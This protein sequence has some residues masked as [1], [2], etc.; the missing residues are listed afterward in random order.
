M[1][2]R[3]RWSLATQNDMALELIAMDDQLKIREQRTATQ[4]PEQASALKVCMRFLCALLAAVSVCGAQHDASGF[5]YE[6]P[7]SNV[8]QISQLAGL[9]PLLAQLKELGKKQDSGKVLQALYVRQQILER[10]TGTSLQVDA[11]IARIEGEVAQA[12][13]YR[14]VL[15]EK[16]DRLED[17]LNLA[18]F[19]TGGALGV[20]SS[21]LQI[22]AKHAKAGNSV[23]IGAGVIVTAISVMSLRAQKGKAASLTFRSN[24]LAPLLNRPTESVDVY[25][26]VV[27]AFLDS[28]PAV[29]PEHLTRK[30]RLMKTWLEMGRLDDLNTPKGQKKID[31]LTEFSAG[32][33]QQSID[34]LYDRRAMLEDLRAKVALI[35]RDLAAV[36]MTLP[37]MEP[38]VVQ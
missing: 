31:R 28:V 37:Q 16:R 30:Q 3:D 32:G 36:L 2:L 34:D 6:D 1:R 27:L 19:A 15:S 5:R 25:S 21:A 4:K 20:V 17:R 8:E 12:N 13:E 11:T 10:V 14:N 29:D 9:T 22:S 33:S 38:G 26:P 24:M 7:E 35:K 23:G 18:G